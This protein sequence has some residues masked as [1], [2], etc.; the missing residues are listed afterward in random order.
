MSLA[1]RVETAVLRGWGGA[2][3]CYVMALLDISV[4]VS[5]LSQNKAA[6]SM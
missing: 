6:L 5:V 2:A 4:A 3:C 1:A